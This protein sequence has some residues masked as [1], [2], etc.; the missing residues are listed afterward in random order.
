[1][2]SGPSLDDARRLAELRKLAIFDTPPEAEYDG[3]A[4]LAASVLR[5]PVAALNFVDGERHYT[6]AIVGMPEA[7]GGS[8]P[9]DVSFCAATVQTPDG[10]LMV[11]DTGADDR[12]ADHP[13]VTG[14][15]RVGFYAGVAIHSRGERVGVLCAFGST[16]RDISADE[17]RAL[18]ALA[19]Q[20]EGQ[21][22]LSRRNAELRNLAVTDPLTGLANRTLLHD[23]LETALADRARSGEDVG[24]V[25]CDVDDFKAVNDRHGHEQ[26]DAVLRGVA[27]DLRAAVRSVD[28]VARVAGDE[29]V[30]VCRDMG[31]SGLAEL[32]DRVGAARD[33]RRTSGALAPRLSMGAIVAAPHDTAASVLRRA[34]LAM[35]ADKQGRA[36]PPRAA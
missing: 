1:M 30:V 25:F 35:Y 15:P 10:V 29:F 24:V 20:A 8:V 26:G 14:G 16:A 32:L 33:R 7:E 11:P 3:L 6:K 28:T 18:T 17:Q 23:R 12:F 5:S 21:L 27:D 31:E 34:D 4:L 9:N 13:L 36:A 19:R 2:S 22:E